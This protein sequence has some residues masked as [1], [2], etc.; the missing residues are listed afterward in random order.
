VEKQDGTTF[1]KELVNT[2]ENKI[3]IVGDL[4]I[5]LLNVSSKL[6]HHGNTNTPK[7]ISNDRINEP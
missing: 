3:H 7:N 1:Q 5:P 6:K 4:G 2:N